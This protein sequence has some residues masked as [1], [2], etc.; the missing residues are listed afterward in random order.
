MTMC[1]RQG[2]RERRV[3]KITSFFAT[4]ADAE[5]ASPASTNSKYSNDIVNA[6]NAKL[7]WLN[8]KFACSY[9]FY[10]TTNQ[11]LS[12]LNTFWRAIYPNP[13]LWPSPSR[14]GFAQQL[15]GD[16]GPWPGYLAVH[17]IK[18]VGHQSVVKLPPPRVCLSAL[19]R[20]ESPRVDTCPTPL[21]T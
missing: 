15:A 1:K 18:A 9:L 7:P 17:P 13:W 11:S 6:I 2:E 8:V 3:P 5:N 16:L 20:S 12:F 19:P 4:A 21:T 14:R 10:A